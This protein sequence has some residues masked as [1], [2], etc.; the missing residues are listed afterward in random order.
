M[1]DVSLPTPT[2]FATI[3]GY[4][5]D[6]GGPA[7]VGEPAT[8]I[9]FAENGGHPTLDAID[10]TAYPDRPG[11]HAPIPG[12][13]PEYS[14]GLWQI[15]MLAHPSYSEAELLTGLGNA[16][17]AVAISSNGTDFSPWTTAVDGAYLKYLPA[18]G[19]LAPI[20]GQSNELESSAVAP[21]AIDAWAVLQHAVGTDLTERLNQSAAHRAAAWGALGR[22]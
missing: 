7:T 13:L 16:K 6:A 4:W 17:A 2:L 10:N 9:A 20:A 12:A 18:G 15:N 14:V 1:S 3:E 21:R 5:D 22:G 11:Y 19:P 8:A